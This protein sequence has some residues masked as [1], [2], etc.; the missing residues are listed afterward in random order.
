VVL[1]R[2]VQAGAAVLVGV[3]A[4]RRRP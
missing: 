3:L 4:Y 1:S 2:A